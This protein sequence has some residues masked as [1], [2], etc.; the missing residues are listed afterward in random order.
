ML[1]LLGYVYGC[2][3]QAK[4]GAAYLLIAAQLSPDDV[5]VLRT[6]SYLLTLDGEADKAL[7]TIS[8]LEVLDGRRDP[9]LH[10]LKSRALYAAGRQEEARQAFNLF[11]KMRAEIGA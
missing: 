7:E 5:G 1:H 3:G 4:R 9:A 2:H 6:L 11:V 8:R 10:L